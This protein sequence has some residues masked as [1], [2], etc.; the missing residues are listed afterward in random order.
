MPQEINNNNNFIQG[1]KLPFL[2]RRQLA[3]EFFF[4]SPHGKMLSPKSVDAQR[5]SKSLT[6]LFEDGPSPQIYNNT[7]IGCILQ[8]QRKGKK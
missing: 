6:Y 4:Q 2:G 5:I 8:M 7:K 1:T 3:I